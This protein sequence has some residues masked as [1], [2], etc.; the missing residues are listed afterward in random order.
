MSDCCSSPD[1]AGNTP[2]KHCCPVSGRECQRV[3]ATTILHNISRPWLW[4]VKNQGYYFC[5]DPKCDVV[6]FGQDDSVITTSGLRIPVGVK[7]ETTNS[8]LCYCFG[9][10]LKDAI[11]NPEVKIFVAKRTKEKQCA[12]NIKNPSGRCCLK[13]FPS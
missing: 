13:D 4:T 12:C 1:A 11:T 8:M 9:I 6:Y 2:K 10:T 7:E 3:S 5:D